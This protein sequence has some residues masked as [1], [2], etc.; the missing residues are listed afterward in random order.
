[1]VELL[2]TWEI[3]IVIIIHWTAWYPFK[4]M[5]QDFAFGYR[6]CQ[7]GPYYSTV[8]YCREHWLSFGVLQG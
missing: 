2:L 7:M 6:N 3:R 4:A 1:M 8:Q 5:D